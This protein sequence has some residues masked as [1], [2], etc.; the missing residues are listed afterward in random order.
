MLKK[1]ILQGIIQGIS[2]AFTHFTLGFLKPDKKELKPKQ[3]QNSLIPELLKNHSDQKKA[4]HQIR[5]SLRKL[6]KEAE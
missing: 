1:N 6:K 4:K 2:E 5:K 3:S